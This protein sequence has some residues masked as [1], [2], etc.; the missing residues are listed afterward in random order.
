[1]FLVVRLHAE[2]GKANPSISLVKKL[3]T[4][5]GKAALASIKWAGKKVDLAIATTITKGIP[6][7]GVIVGAT[8]DDRIHKV[9]DAVRAWLELVAQKLM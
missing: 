1:M 2:F 8:Y 5:L 6:A 9:I 4:A 3:G 7:I